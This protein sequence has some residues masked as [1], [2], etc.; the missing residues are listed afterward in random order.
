MLRMTYNEDL[1]ERDNDM[2]E[3]GDDVTTM[4]KKSLKRQSK[5]NLE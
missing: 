3:D 2:D 5:Q 1:M 4:M